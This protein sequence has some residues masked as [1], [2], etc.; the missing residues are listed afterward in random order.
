MNNDCIH[1][2]L[3]LST[4]FVRRVIKAFRAI[5]MK[6]RNATF[7]VINLL[8][9]QFYDGTNSDGDNHPTDSEMWGVVD[10]RYF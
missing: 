9:K 6:E 5:F 7:E 1:Y 4:Q 8:S 10:A 2:G 3:I